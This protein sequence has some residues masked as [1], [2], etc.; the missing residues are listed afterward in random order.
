MHHTTRYNF[1]SDIGTENI[2]EGCT[3]AHP[4]SIGEAFSGR[5]V[6]LSGCQ[7]L[8]LVP[9]CMAGCTELV[10]QLRSTGFVG[11]GIP[12]FRIPVDTASRSP[13]AASSSGEFSGP[14]H[15]GFQ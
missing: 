8:S 2:M 12:A 1:L 4:Q 11:T 14:G 13:A 5:G 3:A 15:E 9:G 10:P 6:C 7:P